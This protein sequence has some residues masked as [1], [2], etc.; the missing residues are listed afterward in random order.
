MNS[1][2]LAWAAERLRERARAALPPGTRYEIR[3]EPS[4]NYGCHFGMA[5]YHAVGM[6]SDARWE[7]GT[8]MMLD[9][10]GAYTLYERGMT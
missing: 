4:I 5:W 8:A 9:I 6:E 2:T 1:T 7:N 3:L 10:N